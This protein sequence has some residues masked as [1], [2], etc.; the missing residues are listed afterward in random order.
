MFHH[1]RNSKTIRESAHL[2][3][4]EVKVFWE[5][6]GIP[7]RAEQNVLNKLEKEFNEWKHLKK[8]KI[9]SLLRKKIKRKRI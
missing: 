3:F 8:I 7:V 1:K 4:N 9:V 2:V 5:K 6:A